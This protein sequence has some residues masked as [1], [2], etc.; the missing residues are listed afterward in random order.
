MRVPSRTA[1]PFSV[2]F[3]FLFV[4]C[5]GP[6]GPQGEQGPQGVR[7]NYGP[8]GHGVE[9]KTVT[10]KMSKSDF[11]SGSQTD[12]RPTAE[13]DLPEIT[14][15]DKERGLVVTAMVCNEAQTSC[16]AARSRRFFGWGYYFPSHRLGTVPRVAVVYYATQ[17]LL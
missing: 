13:Y 5:E 3:P 12:Y 4:A 9:L 11:Y 17:A 10:R 6:V 8:P 2:A 15:D 16:V 1:L 14:R 7:G